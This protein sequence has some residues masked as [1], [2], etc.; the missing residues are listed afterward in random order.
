[1]F[2]K[3]TVSCHI[4]LAKYENFHCSTTLAIFGM[5]RFLIL[6]LCNRYL[7]IS[8][9]YFNL[10]FSKCCYLATFHIL[11]ALYLLLWSGQTFCSFIYWVVCLYIIKFK[12]CFINTDTGPSSVMWFA[13]IAKA[14][15]FIASTLTFDEQKFSILKKSNLS[16]FFSV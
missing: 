13:N 5:A 10:Y 8:H 11:F 7:L 16:I 3:V 15:L 4:P 1:M 14:C 2:H 6:R 12:T 9:H